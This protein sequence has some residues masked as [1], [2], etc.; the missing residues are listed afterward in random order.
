VNR[1]IRL[2]AEASE[3]LADAATWYEQQRPGL[4][5]DFFAEIESSLAR[6]CEWPYAAPVVGGLQSDDVVRSARLRRFPYR[7]VYV[8][9]DDE[10]RVL[11]VS[12]IRREPR[13]WQ[14]RTLCGTPDEPATD[15]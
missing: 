14:G 7:I 5:E 11:A 9:R 3:E 6:V 4:S 15:R 2:E 12:H 8:V 1:A 13:Y 10:I